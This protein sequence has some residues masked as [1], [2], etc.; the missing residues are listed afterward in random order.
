MTGTDAA[1]LTRR[2]PEWGG[3]FLIGYR[4]IW[5]ALFAAGLVM[6]GYFGPRDEIASQSAYAAAAALGFAPFLNP[7]LEG[8]LGAPLG[9]EG[10]RIGYKNSDLLLTVDGRP[11]PAD[12][13]AQAGVLSG[14]RGSIAVLGLR[15]ATGERYT[16]RVARDPQ[17]LAAAYAGWH[18]SFQGRRWVQFGFET[19]SAVAMIAA[20]A[21]LFIRRPRDLVAQL[22]SFSIVLTFA[23][24]AQLLHVAPL[25]S[26]IIGLFAQILLLTALLLFPDGRLNTRWHRLAGLMIIATSVLSLINFWFSTA[27]NVSILVYVAAIATIMLA[28]VIQYRRTPSGIARQQGK[29]V[30]FGI[31]AFCI[32]GV[33]N[34]LLVQLELSLSSAGALAWATLAAHVVGELAFIAL[35]A[36]LLVSMLRYRLYDA[37]TAISRSVVY[38][39][40]TLALLAIFAGSEK[41][42]EILGE[43]YFGERLGALA[44]GLGAAFAAIMMV[45]LHHRVTHW[46]EHRFQGDLVHLRSALPVLVGDMSTTATPARLADTVLVRIEKGVRAA[47]AAIVVDHEVLAARDVDLGAVQTWLSTWQE[48]VE[49]EGQLHTNRDDPLFPMRVPLYADSVGSVGWILLGPRPDGSFYGKDERDTLLAIAEPVARAIVVARQ[50]EERDTKREERDIG[51][52]REIGGLSNRMTAVETRLTGIAP[53]DA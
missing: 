45:P 20:A 25:V 37:E 50:R 32:L 9:D 2:R 19:A 44:G 17:R 18:I 29:F 11:V 47:H 23:P 24:F 38:G 8:Q 14:P 48:P 3:V 4:V 22:L 12:K 36:G 16:V 5:L 30:L 46:A 28:V 27:G 41:V 43:Q 21:L 6:I 26:T 10:R 33:T 52:G 31:V 1:V 34:E 15:H 51:R 49:G 13:V 40:L 7:S 53:Q 35:P 42:I 39:T